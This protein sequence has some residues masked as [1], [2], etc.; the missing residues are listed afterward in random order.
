MYQGQV[1][2]G[3]KIGTTAVLEL[4]PPRYFFFP[5]PFHSFFFYLN[6]PMTVTDPLGISVSHF[7]MMA[8]TTTPSFPICLWTISSPEAQTVGDYKVAHVHVYTVYL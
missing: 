7:Q 4:T 1:A 3:F 2:F 8:A 5:L 6:H